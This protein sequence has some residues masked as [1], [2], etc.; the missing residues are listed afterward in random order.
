MLLSPGPL[1]A[2]DIDYQKAGGAYLQVFNLMTSGHGFVPFADLHWF[3]NAEVVMDRLVSNIQSKG[4]HAI[5]DEL[6]GRKGD[7]LTIVGDPRVLR[8]EPMYHGVRIT[9]GTV[10]WW[11]GV[12]KLEAAQL[13][14]IRE[15]VEAEANRKIIL[16]R[17]DWERRQRQ[18]GLISVTNRIQDVVQEGGSGI[19]N[20]VPIS[21]QNWEPL[22]SAQMVASMA[23]PLISPLPEYGYY[24]GVPTLS[25]I[26][27]TE[28]IPTSMV[29]NHPLQIQVPM[30]H[31]V[32]PPVSTFL[33]AS[34][35]SPQIT[36]PLRAAGLPNIALIP[37]TLGQMHT[38]NAYIPT[39]IPVATT[40]GANL[41]TQSDKLYADLITNRKHQQPEDYPP[42]YGPPRRD[43]PPH[44]QKYTTALRFWDETAIEHM[45][46]SERAKFPWRKVSDIEIDVQPGELLTYIAK[47]DVGNMWGLNCWCGRN[48]RGEYGAFPSRVVG[49][50][51]M[52]DESG[53]AE[54]YDM[55]IIRGGV[56]K[57][58]PKSNPQLRCCVSYVGPAPTRETCVFRDIWFVSRT[59][60][61][62][63]DDHEIL[64]E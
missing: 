25:T 24:V 6:T 61:C 21:H 15:I 32:A 63:W 10:G 56:C 53:E 8:N 9:T 43:W 26:T 3:P 38:M 45:T 50:L 14:K 39:N 48:S 2:P 5:G 11:R 31:Q 55:A 19:V 51:D 44:Y 35:S 16:G 52:D 7:I 47:P 33:P 17:I 62:C 22:H 36:Q 23:P 54:I 46:G 58:H 40:S 1:H 34:T 41:T 4:Q 49:K 13:E 29:M 37:A 20:G 27:S 12:R 42:D 59:H 30:Q 64:K 57:N 60:V 18:M 28:S